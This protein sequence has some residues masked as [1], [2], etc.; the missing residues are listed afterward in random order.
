V[1]IDK[2]HEFFTESGS[3]VARKT[4]RKGHGVDLLR[5]DGSLVKQRGG[6]QGHPPIFYLKEEGSKTNKRRFRHSGHQ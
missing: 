4:G 1:V 3:R 5:K 6:K 2:E